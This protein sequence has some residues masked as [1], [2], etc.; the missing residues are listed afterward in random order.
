MPT[1]TMNVFLL[2]KT[3]C[4]E[5]N[6]LLDKFWQKNQKAERGLHWTNWYK[7]SEAKNISSLGFRDIQ[8]YNKT[9]SAKRGWKLA[10]EPD[11]LVSKVYKEKF[12]KNYTYF[13]ATLGHFLSDRWRSVLSVNECIKSRSYVEGWKW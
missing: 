6:T 11:S 1:Y 10:Q 7:L 8:Q 2:P 12:L 4:K 5:I 9:M 3:L 13:E